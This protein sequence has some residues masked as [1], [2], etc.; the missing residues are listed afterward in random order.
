MNDFPD[1]PHVLSR[2]QNWVHRVYFYDRQF[3]IFCFS[4]RVTDYGINKSWRRVYQWKGQ[5]EEFIAQ[6]K[7]KSSSFESYMQLILE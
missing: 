3:Q 2:S 1:I 5:F 7:S 4:G 6:I